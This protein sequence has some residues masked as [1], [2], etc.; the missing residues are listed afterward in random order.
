MNNI[1][2]N[3]RSSIKLTGSKT[4]YFD[5]YKIEE[6]LH[7]AV[8]RLAS[9]IAQKSP[10]ALRKAIELINY[11]KHEQYREGIKREAVEFGKIF[12]SNDA[13]EGISAFIEKRQ[14]TF[15]GK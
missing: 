10:L 8:H 6:E 14:P 2:V 13:Q 11:T 3:T 5:P 9:K 15:V 7:D 12:L 4:I 1:F